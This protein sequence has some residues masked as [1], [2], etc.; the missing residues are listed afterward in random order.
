LLSAEPRSDTAIS[1]L[2]STF[3]PLRFPTSHL[4][5]AAVS[6]LAVLPFVWMGIPSGHDFEF[7]MF[8]WMEVASQW[9][10]GI[11]YPRWAALA[12][13]GYGE[14]RFVFYPPASWTLGAALGF[15]LPWKLVPAAYCWIALS[16]AGFSMYRLARQWLPVPDA[17]F[18][19]AF[20]AVNPYH[21]VIVYWRGA[22]AELLA[23]SLL[24]LLL[25]AILKLREP[26]ASP[27]L[28]LA[29]VLA[30]AWL[31]NA[32]AALMIHYSAAGL[33]LLL[34]LHDRSWKPLLRGTVAVI[35]GAGLASFYL[36]PAIYEERWINIGEVLAAGVRP[37][38][39][40]LFT[41]TTDAD[42]NRFNFL[43]SSVALAEIFALAAAVWFSR[44]ERRRHRPFG[45]LVAAWGAATALLLFSLSQPLWQ[46]LPKFRYVQLPFRWLLCL[47]AMLALLITL[48]FR[49]R[50]A[51]ILGS[52]AMLAAILFVA[53]RIQPP[54]W[55]TAA[56]IQ[57][58]HDAMS[59]GTGNEGIDEYVPA[60]TDPYEASKDLPLVSGSGGQKLHFQVSRWAPEDRQFVVE[61]SAP[62]VL[63]VRLFDYPAWRTTVRGLPVATGRTDESGLLLVPV[64]A[65]RSEVQ[66]HFSRTWDRTLGGIMSLVS[67]SISFGTW[68]L[69]HY[70]RSV[71]LSGASTSRSEV[72][73]E[74]KDPYFPNE[75]RKES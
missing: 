9:R 27:A 3:T 74:S 1:K 18:A 46:Y 44:A 43:I 36:L 61:T 19:A 50:A 31:V 51:R 49:R 14:A 42:H 38:D 56:D 60:G 58:M 47:N 34:S 67:L 65:G 45:L 8:S 52:A 24:P 59:D 21:L 25:I 12:H 13:W 72:D 73:A 66:I 64:P 54:W 11:V 57:E 10:Q 23:A 28:V 30:A 22:F 70:Q 16:L 68:L 29:L 6:F 5:L 39:N 63:T 17:L 2:T 32:P 48:A 15:V 35:L 69:I 62:I 37:Q 55:D 4:V 40:F 20:Y 41:I 71:I 33:A 26:G 7:H 53:Y 75:R